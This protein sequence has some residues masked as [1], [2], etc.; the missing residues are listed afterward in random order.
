MY[1]VN[2]LL[3]DIILDWVTSRKCLY[4]KCIKHF[5][6]KVGKTPFLSFWGVLNNYDEC[7]A[8][9]YQTVFWIFIQKIQMYK[10]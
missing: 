7:D 10:I 4:L 3:T 1:N 9:V 5:G 2:K 8:T 6:G